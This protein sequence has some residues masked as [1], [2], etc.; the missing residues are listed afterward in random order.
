LI[1]HDGTTRN[2]RGHLALPY[3]IVKR[4]LVHVLSGVIVLGS[5]A[6]AWDRVASAQGQPPASGAGVSPPAA[7]SAQSPQSGTAPAPLAVRSSEPATLTY[8]NRPIVVLRAQVLGRSPTERALGVVRALDDLVEQGVTAPVESRV[9]DGGTIVSV[10]G[11]GVLALTPPDADELAGETL[12]RVASEATARLRQALDEYQEARRPGMLIWGAVLALAMLALAVV[13]LRALARAR[14]VATAWLVAISG[15]T[16]EQTG[17][18]PL[19]APGAARILDVPR[20]VAAAVFLFLNLVVVYTALTFILR[21]FPYTR[22]WGESMRGFLLTTVERLG[23][24]AVNA[25]PGLFTVFVILVATRFVAGLVRLWFDAVEVGRITPRW[26]HPDTAGPTRRLA[27]GMLWLLAI[28]VAYP[29]MPGSETEAFKGISVFL[30]L[31][32]TFGSSGFVNQ[33]M[34]GFMITY[35][36]A[37]RIGDFVRIGEVE[38]TVTFVGMLSTKLRTV[39]REE[40]TVPNALVVSQTTV[41][42]S[43][44]GNTDGVLTP[45]SVTIGYDTPWRQVHAM[46]LAAAERT[47]GLS[48]LPQPVVLQTALDDFAVKYTLLVGLERQDARGPVMSRLHESIQDQFNEHGVQIMTPHYEGDP[49]GIKIVPKQKWYPAP[50]RPDGPDH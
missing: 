31:L 38:G 43:R 45:T 14:R 13:V 37:L 26:I 8:F 15:K 28:V 39:R 27:T 22:P 40:V 12:E 30:G 19:E 9:T 33:I 32:V 29:Y 2:W 25:L 3:A 49:E 24:S 10:G 23:L 42:Y 50:A 4:S 36:R 6:L 44:P 41:D 34:S 47:P 7:S 21:R 35:S 17:I 20:F 5:F 46:L 1:L 48:R 16:I 11:R 18:A